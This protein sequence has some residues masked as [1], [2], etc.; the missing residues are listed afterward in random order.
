MISPQVFITGGGGYLGSLL[1]KAYLTETDLDVHLWLHAQNE[2]DFQSKRERLERTFEANRARLIYSWGD[3][4][5]PH[6]F[7][8]TSPNRIEQVIHSAAVTRFNI[9]AETARSVNVEGAKKLLHFAEQCPKLQALGVISTVYASG[10]QAGSIEERAA[11]GE[12]GFANHYE[13]SKWAAET[14]LIKDFAHLP[15]RILRTGTVI[16]DDVCGTV[17]QY[18]AVH[19]T[20]KLLYYGLLPLLPGHT[21]TPLYFVTGT[22]VTRAIFEL[23]ARGSSQAVYH[24]AHT[25][26]ESLSLETLI[27]CVFQ[28]FSEDPDFVRR[29]VMQP[30]FAD[31]E[32]FSL[33]ASGVS[34]FSGQV[35]NQAVSSISPFAKQLFIEKAVQNH[36]LRAALPSYQAPDPRELVQRICAY[37]VRT[38]WGREVVHAS[39]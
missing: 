33:L 21:Q 8:S 4:A 14:L 16:A 7:A 32:S 23:M 12:A 26:E 30:L 24:V 11:T 39:V 6:P 5:S 37:L 3:L 13:Q 15:W 20:L 27:G 34:R 29:R 31:H 22:F 35:V 25:K 2:Q 28:S 18:N 38:K 17:T 36:Q 9:D 1:A 10:L 19:N